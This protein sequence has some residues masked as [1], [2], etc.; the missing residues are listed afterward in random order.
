[1]SA[2]AKP[3][4][5]FIVTLAEI[6]ER[7]IARARA[8]SELSNLSDRD[9]ADIGLSRGDIPAVVSGSFSN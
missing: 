1:M 7:N 5:G 9:L 2:E 8:V 6:I 3:Y 4:R